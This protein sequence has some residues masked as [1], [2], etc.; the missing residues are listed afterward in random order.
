VHALFGRS[1][2]PARAAPSAAYKRPIFT[3]YFVILKSIEIGGGAHHLELA[4]GST[5]PAPPRGL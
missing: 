5:F 3:I 1:L 2:A 4:P